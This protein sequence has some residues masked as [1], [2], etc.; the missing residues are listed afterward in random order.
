[1]TPAGRFVATFVVGGFLG[2]GSSTHHHSETLNSG[3]KCTARV[4]AATERVMAMDREM[5]DLT[6]GNGQPSQEITEI[7]VTTLLDQYRTGAGINIDAFKA[8]NSAVI[9]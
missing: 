8:D 2:I 4:T 3:E 5:T 7:T 9:T 1:M 6:N